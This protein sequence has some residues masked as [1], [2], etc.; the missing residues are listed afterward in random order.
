ML[1]SLNGPRHSVRTHTGF[2]R[3]PYLSPR[4]CS[5]RRIKLDSRGGIVSWAEC[6][7]ALSPFWA[8]TMLSE[9]Y[10]VALKHIERLGERIALAD[11]RI[12]ELSTTLDREVIK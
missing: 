10:T 5:H 12:L 11:A 8:L 1:L 7:A 9:Q 2:E 3:R 6:G 4:D